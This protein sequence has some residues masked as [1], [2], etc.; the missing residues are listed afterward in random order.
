MGRQAQSILTDVPIRIRKVFI[1]MKGWRPLRYEFCPHMLRHASHFLQ[2][3][4]CRDELTPREAAPHSSPLRGLTPSSPSRE[5]KG[6]VLNRDRN[7]RVA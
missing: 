2:F 1:H 7:T 5:V 3:L 6:S 4:S